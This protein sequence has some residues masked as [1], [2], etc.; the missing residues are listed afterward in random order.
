MPP[1]NAAPCALLLGCKTMRLL[2]TG[3]HGFVGKTLS[4]MVASDPA[5][6]SWQ[7]VPLSERFDLTDAKAV[8]AVVAEAKPEAIVH[9]A[10]VSSV[11]QS[12]RDSAG[13]LRVN[14]LGTLNLLEALRDAAFRGPMVFAS[15]GEVYGHVPD[16]ALPI[17]ETRLAAPRSPYAVSKVAAEALC[18]Q[19]SVTDRMH[20]AIA[21]PFN[22]IGAGQ[23]ADFAIAAFAAQV[24]SIRRGERPAVIEV[25]D[26][27][28]TRDFTDVRDV[29]R[30]YFALLEHGA[31]GECYN[32]CS[33]RERSLRELLQRL[34]AL[35]GIEAEVRRDPARMRPVEQ[36]RAAGNPAKIRSA[37]G[38]LADTP[39]DESLRAVLAA[40]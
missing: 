24:A 34:M 4:G 31:P 2:V 33:G 5:L 17:A 30:A 37:T 40:A 36:R 29:V 32:V 38:W 14:V 22:H 26:L 21:R 35:A 9:L 11:A 16:D 18:Y 1:G 7:L 19:W 39:I 15:S 20:I 28:V 12:M 8:R 27:D 10:A 23:S 3:V 13:T 25:G 6:V